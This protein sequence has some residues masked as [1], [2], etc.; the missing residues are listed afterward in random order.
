MTHVHR[1]PVPTLEAA[2]IG[3]QSADYGPAG[4][5]GFGLG[6]LAASVAQAFRP[7]PGVCTFWPDGE[8]PVDNSPRPLAGEGGSR[9]RDG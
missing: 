9:M 7:A 3:S 8:I 2:V 6:E 5:G 1:L 4:Q